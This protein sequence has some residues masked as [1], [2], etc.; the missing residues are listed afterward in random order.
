MSLLAS[1][2]MSYPDA[3]A[4][5]RTD[6]TAGAGLV[7][8]C[9][10][11]DG[12]ADAAT[13]HA[14]Y[15]RHAAL[16][17]DVSAILARGVGVERMLQE[18]AECL[19]RHL[20]AVLARFWTLRRGADILELRAS[21]G[22][23]TNLNGQHSRI[24]LGHLK[25]GIIARDGVPCLSNDVRSD[26]RISDKDWACREGIVAFAGYPLV[27][28]E[29]VVGVV[30]MFAR[31]ALDTDTLE[32]LQSLAVAVA[33]GVERKRAEEELQRSA[34]YLAE[35][36]RLSHTGSWAWNLDTGELFMSRETFSIYGLEATD[37]PLTY[38]TLLQRSHPDDASDV[39]LAIKAA[40]GHGTELRLFTRLC[41]PGQPMKWVKTYGHPVH[42]GERIVEY[43]ATVIDVT[44]QIHAN[45]RQRHALRARYRAVIAE[46]T[47]I[48]RD[49]HDGFLQD[50]AG[51]A[52]QLGAVLPHVR[53]EAEAERVRNILALTER[54][55]REVRRTVL[56]M[57]ERGTL[58]DLASAVHDLVRR[59]ALP[60]GVA[61]STSVTGNAF[62]IPALMCDA[63]VSVAHEA[64]TNALKHSEARSITVALEFRRRIIR[65]S[66]RDDGCGLS[67][68]S[69][70]RDAAEHGLGLVGMRER[71][72]AIG[73]TL[74]VSSA[75]GDGTVV[76]L[77]VPPVPTT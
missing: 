10:R 34:A 69:N 16:R 36:Q 75:P 74:R 25:I 58:V 64:I 17:A 15:A 65:M 59:T 50:L 23:Y 47:R 45:R 37:R 68:E 20:N 12:I 3:G 77:D 63:I 48:A 5:G 13:D 42:D 70:A 67:A 24:P 57:R 27:V 18:C 28:E 33:Q 61:F 26:P 55:A 29:R 54:T 35:G 6:G 51:I 43:I 49:L 2:A 19:V 72:G 22:A 56:G 44:E 11:D 46:R 31:H 66:V 52:M 39:A 73:A 53:G 4:P 21:A 76:R 40:L 7:A 9:S 8:M 32:T 60:A 71:A 30:G 41:I 62:A 1:K 14:R 38:E